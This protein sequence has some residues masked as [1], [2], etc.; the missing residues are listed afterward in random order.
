MKF[1]NL[2]QVLAPTLL[3]ASAS[4]GSVDSKSGAEPP[5][6][7][8]SAGTVDEAGTLALKGDL[9][10]ADSDSKADQ[11]VYTLESLPENGTV[12]HGDT[13]LAVGDTF[14][15]QDVN[16]GKVSYVN[17]GAEKTSDTFNWSLTD[18]NTS[19]GPLPF[20][21]TVN[22]VN[23]APAIVNN[24]MTQ[25]TEGAESV[26]TADQL[27]VSDAETSD[28]AM[29][30]FTITAITHGTMQVK[31]GVGA[32]ASVGV[33]GTFTQ[34]DINNGNV[35]FVD[36][37]VDDTNL[38]AGNPT[39]A[40]FGWKVADPDGGKTDAASTFKVMPFDDAPTV[41]WVASKCYA[42]TS[43]TNFVAAP[44]LTTITDPDTP[45]SAY[46]VCITGFENSSMVSC[47]TGVTSGPQCTTTSVA[48][49]VKNGS[50]VLALNSCVAVTA[51]SGITMG[52]TQNSAP[53][54]GVYWQLKKSG[55]AAG[56][57]NLLS[58]V[59]CP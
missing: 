59:T 51:L 26:L 35:K 14:T 12:M 6:N 31:S 38:A 55:N 8:T 16:D 18:G 56:T 24:G 52:Q 48:P 10:T 49:T 1:V 20:A 33:G 19:I 9:V 30:T 37:G 32:F 45:L 42:W 50:T 29:L 39:T 41:N 2:K 54:G 27:T 5:V 36:S 13:T 21:I 11:L 28:P 57:A 25:I 47:P 3:L 53:Y 15:Q 46:T 22:P 58:L 23:D 17:N 40:S 7:A 44:P 43:V 4:C 34:A